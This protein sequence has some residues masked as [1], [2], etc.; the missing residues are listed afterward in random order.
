MK[1]PPRRANGR[2]RDQRKGLAD[3]AKATARTGGTVAVGRKATGTVRILNDEHGNAA[4]HGRWTRADRTRSDW[5]ILP[6]AP[7]IEPCCYPSDPECSHRRAAKAQ[8]ARMAYGVKLKG[9]T[10]NAT[11][12]V[13][14]YA[15]RRLD[16]REGRVKSI[17]DERSRMRDHVLPLLGRLDARTFTTED[18]ERVRDDLDAKIVSGE[19][20]WKTARSCWTLVT[21]MCA[22][23]VTAKRREFRVRKDNPARDVKPPEKGAR[24][25]KQF[26]HP[27]E[28][29]QFA[30]C[31]E[32]PLRWRRAVALA[33]YTFTRDGELRALEWDTGDVD[34]SHGVLK[35]TRAYSERSGKVDTTKTADTRS[36]AIEPALVPLL[37]AMHKE[38]KGR[39]AV[40]PFHERHMTRA[41]R[42]HLWRA[43]VR[44]PELHEDSPTRKALTWHDLRA[45]GLTWMAVRGDDPLKIKQRAGHAAFSTTELYVRLAESVRE[46][47]GEPFPVLPATLLGNAPN[48]PGR[49]PDPLRREIAKVFRAG[50]GSRTR[51]LRLGNA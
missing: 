24:K 18:V 5:L 30:A 43:G 11:E 48:R 28:F 21:S 35:V 8:C 45:T 36:F 46:G 26:L 7:P 23:M 10:G 40:L 49:F 41:L 4:W 6:G 34:L 13:A 19:L 17:R 47:F 1:R 37:E 39:G 33:I 2:G 44:R 16:E 51:D 12:T 3:G 27:D 42:R 31:E 38:S 50:H 14:D 20:A 29:L 9:T 25:A 32:V 22:D 15:K